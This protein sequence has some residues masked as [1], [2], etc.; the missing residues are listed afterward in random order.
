MPPRGRVAIIAAFVA[1]AGCGSGRG[2]TRDGGPGGA[3]GVDDAGA[4]VLV[5]PPDELPAPAAVR[6]LA[7]ATTGFD[8]IQASFVQ[9]H[10]T[11]A[12]DGIE[13]GPAALSDDGSNAPAPPYDPAACRARLRELGIHYVD[14]Q[15]VRGIEDSIVVRP[16]IGGV[17]F[18]DG[19]FTG[20]ERPLLMDCRLAISLHRMAVQLRQT[21]RIV[22]L[23][24]FGIYNYRCM[25][26][27]DP[28]RPSTHA[29]GLG[30]DIS[31]FRDE[32]GHVFSVRDDFEPNGAPTCPARAVD[33]DDQTLKDIACWLYGSRTF[34]LVLT[35][36]YNEA[37]HNHFHLDLTNIVRGLGPNAPGEIDPPRY[38]TQHAHGHDGASDDGTSDD[39]DEP[40]EGEAPAGASDSDDD[41]DDSRPGDDHAAPGR[42]CMAPGNR[43]SSLDQWYSCASVGLQGSNGTGADVPRSVAPSAP[44]GHGVTD[45][46]TPRATP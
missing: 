1:L 22:E 44:A 26:N 2:T 18:L 20:R 13:D 3:G 19:T 6:L 12:D 35:P 17:H 4:T 21:W 39:V 7:A 28:C 5:R 29:R 25:P 9:L 46:A 31:A 15:E 14:W 33:G 11:S 45:R 24:H 10:N 43:S 27:S 23:T 40:G 37:H 8:G 41:D 16:P 30:I 32:R 42:V 36:N 34:S 38:L